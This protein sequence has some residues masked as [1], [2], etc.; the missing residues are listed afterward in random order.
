[1]ANTCSGM[2]FRTTHVPAAPT[3]LCGV[4]YG[5]YRQYTMTVGTRPDEV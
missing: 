2:V 3:G 5:I 4:G 1:M